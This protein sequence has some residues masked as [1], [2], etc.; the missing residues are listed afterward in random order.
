MALRA[1]L[2]SVVSNAGTLDRDG[3]QL[4]WVREGSGIPM[5]V[6][7][8][9][10]FYPR[11]FPQQL[12]EHFEIVFCDLRQWVETPGGFDIDSIRLD[13]FCEDI[14]ALRE[15][16]GFAR[17]ILV[18]H[19]QHGSLALE[20]ARRYPR[21]VRGV[22]AIIPLPP[23]GSRDGLE[24]S[25]DFFQRDASSERLAA[26]RRNRENRP[27]PAAIETTQDFV[28]GY[29]ADDAM[30]WFDPSFDASALWDGVE[31]NLEVMN[32]LFGPAVLGA[33]RAQ[34]LDVPVFLILG[35]YD[36][37]FPYYLWDEPKKTFSNLRYKV[38]EKSGHNVPYEQPDEFSADLVEWAEGL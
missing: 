25:E 37:R 20:Y 3:F 17:P 16:V 31:V 1:Q 23:A 38:Y 24:S 4:D 8:A 30:R 10:R 6:L 15:A 33:Y 9:R 14:D 18:G 22:A 28:D 29:L 13:T 27:T 12:R 34:Q 2:G 35:R 11:Y 36:Y 21:R 5:M 19:S 32:H 7:G 26:H